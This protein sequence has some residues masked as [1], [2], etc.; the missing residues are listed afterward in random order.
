MVQAAITTN[1]ACQVEE[2]WNLMW[3]QAFLQKQIQCL[4][5]YLLMHEYMIMQS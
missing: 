3:V 1:I 4:N 5:N 2:T